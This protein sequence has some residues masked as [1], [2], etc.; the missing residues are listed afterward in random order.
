MN[1]LN[2]ILDYLK[3]FNNI[4]K[5][6]AYKPRTMAHGGR[7]GLKYGGILDA[8]ELL[9]SKG[10]TKFESMPDL[11]NTIKEI[12]GKK[13]SG[14]FQ[15]NDPNYK[16]LLE[17]FTFE[18]FVFKKPKQVTGITKISD[19]LGAKIKNV[20][21]KGINVS[22]DTTKA[23][24]KGI[25]VTIQD[26][27]VSGQF[28]GKNKTRV[29]PA[30]EEGLAEV[31][32]LVDNIFTSNIYTLK[33]KPFK[34]PE[35]FRKLKRLKEARY[36]EQ[37]PF[38]IYEAL[39]R[40]KTEKFPGSMS[41]DIQIQHGQ[42]KFT[43]QTLSRW[44]LIPKHV[45]TIPA[46]ERAERLRNELLSRT[47]VKLKNPNRSL[48]DKQIIIDE[49][50]SIFKGLKSQLKGTEGQG[51]VNF[52]LLK[53]DE[54]GNVIK[55]KDIGF[56]PQKG[57]AYGNELGELDFAKISQEQADQ[58]IAL[59]K[60]KIDLELL[61]KV[62]PSK[63][64]NIVNPTPV[65][66]HYES[67]GRVGLSAGGWLVSL[68]G[69]E[70]LIFE[71]VFYKASKNNY[72]SQGYSE[73]EAKALA[74]DEITLGITSK[75]D[76]VYNKELEKVAKEMGIGSKAFDTIREISKRTI[77]GIKQQERD[78]QLL[79]SG[80]FQT[81]EAKDK[82]LDKREKLYGDYNKETE[83]LWRKAKTEIG[84][85]KAGKVFPTP[86]LDQIATESM[87]VK[88]T[89]VQTSFEDLQKVAKEKLR[90][91]KLKAYDIQS[92]QAD[93]EG[94]ST[95][96]P[97]TNWFT[98]AEGFWDWRSSGQEEQRLIDDMVKV[99][100]RELYRYNIARGLHPDKPVTEESLEALRSRHP[101]LHLRD[102]GIAS[103]MKKKW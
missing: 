49:A 98:P 82:F 39:R 66:R 50:N 74:I 31:Q 18:K 91:R 52:E 67:G 78:E 22:P 24:Q 75:G 59:G 2:S 87:N 85:D 4:N 94:G 64:K 100:P 69:P 42:P 84:M 77:K 12:T 20:G 51:L 90:K 81:E 86:N 33:V 21:I 103:L 58:I 19:E 8:L 45:Q 80:Y 73:E 36:K 70:A 47:L 1:N 48:A 102:G 88:D 89:D 32:K 63:L 34:T 101:E 35:Y 60:E 37:D 38:G 3:V 76:K 72:L 16:D 7:I 23:G 95:F 53:L 93:P 62:L 56:N 68:L 83:K 96:R 92:K 26:P 79:E 13:P 14:S 11:K 15:K 28:F 97:I 99:D 71:Y 41:S 43:T 46:V 61:R 30:N 44:G 27:E 57:L 29:F 25:K 65:S 17:Q 9:I 6:P 10:K 40:Y 55:L 54:A 5:R